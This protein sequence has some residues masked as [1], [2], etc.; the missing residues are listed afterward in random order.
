MLTLPLCGLEPGPLT[1]SRDGARLSHR[2][3]R[4]TRVQVYDL[5]TG[6][7]LPPPTPPSRTLLPPS[8]GSRRFPGLRNRVSA[9]GRSGPPLFMLQVLAVSPAGD[10]LAVALASRLFVLTAAAVRAARA[11]GQP[12]TRHPPGVPAVALLNPSREHILGACFTPDARELLTVGS[13]GR[14]RAWET[15]CWTE[16][17]S[18]DFQTGLLVSVAVSPDGLTA[19]AAGTKKIVVW[20][21]DG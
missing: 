5:A 9:H 20:D 6:E 12:A 17:A 18:Y 1:F 13:D 16:R 11:A 8:P 14:V 21:L 2:S 3:A 10:L 15:G 7:P 4:D 19:A